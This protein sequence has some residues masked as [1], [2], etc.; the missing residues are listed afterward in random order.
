MVP[1]GTKN[2][3]ME[4]SKHM[5]EGIGVFSCRQEAARRNEDWYKVEL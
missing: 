4:K 1:I 2:L 5:F 3:G